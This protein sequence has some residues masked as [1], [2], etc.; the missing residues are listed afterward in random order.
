MPFRPIISNNRMQAESH[1]DVACR[2]LDY[3]QAN[4]QAQQH[5]SSVV[6]SIVHSNDGHTRRKR[7]EKRRE[8]GKHAKE[9]H[10]GAHLEKT[11]YRNPSDSIA[12]LNC[13]SEMHEKTLNAEQR[14]GKCKKAVSESEEELGE[15][16]EEEKGHG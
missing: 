8:E 9:T 7:H 2:H 16:R 15:R 12:W 4:A 11:S 13:R 6:V 3:I 1:A 14:Q 5:P 10:A